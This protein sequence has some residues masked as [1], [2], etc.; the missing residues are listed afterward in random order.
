MVHSMRCNPPGAHELALNMFDGM[1]RR[2]FG[3]FS[4]IHPTDL[5]WA[6]ATRGLRFGGLGLR[7]TSSHA[8]AAYIASVGSSLEACA[9]IDA[10]F[11]V[12]AAKAAPPLHQAVAAFNTSIPATEALSVE[13][14][15]ALKQRDLSRHLDIASWNSQLARSSLVEQAT[16]RSEAE[17]GARAFLV[18]I[19]SGACHME[20]PAFLTELRARLAIPDASIDKWCPRCDAVLDAMSH[21]AAMCAAGGNGHNA[22]TQCGMPFS[23]GRNVLGCGLKKNLPG[24]CCLN[25]LTT[26]QCRVDVPPMSTSQP[27][28]E[29]L[30]HLTSPSRRHSDRKLSPWLLTP[31]GPLR[32]HM[33]CTKNSIS[34]PGPNATDR[35]ERSC[36]WWW[37]PRVPGM[38]LPPKFS[39]TWPMQPR[40]AL[41]VP[42]ASFSAPSCKNSASWFALG[43]PELF[44]A[45]VVK[46]RLSLVVSCLYRLPSISSSHIPATNCEPR[47]GLLA[48]SFSLGSVGAPAALAPGTILGRLVTRSIVSWD[49]RILALS[50]SGG[51]L[52]PQ[53]SDPVLRFSVPMVSTCFRKFEVRCR[54]R[55]D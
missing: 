20:G 27:W 7:S 1:V 42:L 10:T 14:A 52:D 48:R 41:A 12:T 31:R 51:G 44:F 2:C 34:K 54:S 9:A 3:D 16:L 21:H 26:P 38:R 40:P 5:Q 23:S 4:G 35:A 36:L 37:S 17:I 47:H 8:A 11:S 22:T 43:G 33:R 32:Q 28:P 18:A 24:F 25:A 46:M 53:W 39:N 15:L 55:L 13:T 29:G 19:P 49:V 30:L 6:Q 50:S 45:D